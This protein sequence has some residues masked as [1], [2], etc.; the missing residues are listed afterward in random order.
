MTL[1]ALVLTC[2]QRS[3][4]LRCME[5]LSVATA[6]ID[7]EIILVDNGSTDGTA[8]V[9]AEKFP[10]VHVVTLDRNAGVAAGRN[11]AMR[12]A[13]GEYF[14]ILDNDTVPTA[15][16]IEGLLA[17]LA[18]KPACGIAAPR[19]D[20]ADGTCQESFKPYPGIKAKVCNVLGIKTKDSCPCYVIGACQ[21]MR[22][23]TVR[24]IGVLDENIF[25]GPEDADYCLRAAEAGYDIDYL[26]NLRM[27]H[28]HRRATRRRLLSPLGRRHIAALFY[29]WRKHRR[30]W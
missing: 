10:S 4:T 24:R 16:V 21:M 28:D 22:A 17:H 26:P 8:A 7:S 20:Y 19:L 1:S 23:E 6:N 25:Y 27:Q 30:W 14:L 3:T 2:N 15:E 12:H 11:E 9:V 5:A 13:R 18:A 29:F